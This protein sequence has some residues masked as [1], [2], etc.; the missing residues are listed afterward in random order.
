MSHFIHV[1]LISQHHIPFQI[2]S[3]QT[4]RGERGRGRE[5]GRERE[6]ERERE[7]GREREREGGRERERGD[8]QKKI[9]TE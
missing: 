2:S 7:G 8:I 5:G 6:G 4:A 9:E 3:Y 1:T